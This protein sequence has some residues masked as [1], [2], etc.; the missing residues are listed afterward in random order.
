MPPRPVR[1]E[2]RCEYPDCKQWG[3]LGFER[4]KSKT[5]WFCMEHRPEIYRGIQVR[6]AAEGKEEAAG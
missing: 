4:D 1:F 5:D 3:G 6:W 2:H